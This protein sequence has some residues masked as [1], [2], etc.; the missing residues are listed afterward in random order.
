MATQQ[1]T[2][3]PPSPSQPLPSSMGKPA[4]RALQGAGITT[5]AE[6]ARRPPE[7]LAKLHGVGPKALR[8]LAESLVAAGLL[9]DPGATRSR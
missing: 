2:Q 1:K 3:P 9:P 6:A 5:L 4:L 8:L 7:E